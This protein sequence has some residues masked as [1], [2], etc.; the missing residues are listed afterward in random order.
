[1][2]AVADLYSQDGILEMQHR[3][4]NN[5]G[6]HI[7]TGAVSAVSSVFAAVTRPSIVTS[8]QVKQR[9]H[10]VVLK[11][12]AAR[13]FLPEGRHGDADALRGFI[14]EI[15]ILSHKPLRDHPNII[16]ILGVNWELES[17]SIAL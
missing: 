11:K 9:R 5:V 3:A 12:S 1:M 16:K 15:R 10:V 6:K 4:G 14:S 17:V 13:L 2:T 7:G 8:H